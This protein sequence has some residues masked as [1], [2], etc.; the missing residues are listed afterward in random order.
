MVGLIGMFLAL[1]QVATLPGLMVMA[2]VEQIRRKSMPE[3]IVNLLEW[4]TLILIIG[5]FVYRS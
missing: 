3:W 4:T 2:T 1:Y 5:W